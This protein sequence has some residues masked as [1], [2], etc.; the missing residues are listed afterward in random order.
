MNIPGRWL[1]FY[2][3]GLVLFPAVINANEF[4]SSDQGSMLVE[5]YTSEGC[6]SCP[7][8]EHYL[9]K[10][11]L[12][13]HLWET[14]FPMAF[15]VDYWDHLG[16]KDRFSNAAFSL[17][18]KQYASYLK[19]SSIYTPAFFINAN[20]WYPGFYNKPLTVKSAAI[21]GVLQFS[22][23]NNQIHARYSNSTMTDQKLILNTAILGMGLTT[24]IER[25]ENAGRLAEHEFVVLSYQ[26]RVSQ[27]LEWQL[28]VPEIVFQGETGRAIIA[29]VT[30][31][32]N[33][34]PLQ[35]AG[36]LLENNIQH[37]HGNH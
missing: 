12:D 1:F 25:G 6:S 31:E 9:N 13:E 15:H 3:A 17:R 33:P 19:H 10:L 11:N 32:D 7:P 5:L 37:G 22:M 16:W 4:I 14:V 30:R 20:V 18:Q 21:T 36:G 23:K 8:A 28:S 26:T 34:R 2:F 29:W 27:K 24:K 35:I